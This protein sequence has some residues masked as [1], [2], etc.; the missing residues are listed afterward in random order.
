MA[1]TLE[2][3]NALVGALGVKVPGSILEER[4]KAEQFAAQRQ[5]ILAE[6]NDKPDEWSLKAIFSEVMAHAADAAGKKQ[7]DAALKHLAEAE[8]LL[9]E[10]DVAP[11][12]PPQPASAPEILTPPPAPQPLPTAAP[13]PEA[14]TT[15]KEGNF[16]LVEL[17]KSRLAYDSLRKS[18]QHQ[19]QQL[20]K[21]ILDGV[22]SH[23][24]DESTEDEFEEGEVAAGVKQL[25]SILQQLDERLIDK[26]DEA[27]NAASDAERQARHK[28]AGKI[29]LEYQAFAAG[30][31]MLATID[32]NGFTKTTIREAVASTLKD[33][34]G[35]W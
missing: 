20:E 34:A 5:K 2:E 35:K 25:Y 22:Q 6:G 31:P 1:L 13:Q 15:S 11:A 10:T 9:Q 18:V 21:S 27:L 16:S 19:L 14:V 30:D 23:N 28:E 3:I 17:Q 7:F 12:P 33:L 26:L 29:V 24:A 4:Q 32:E 8:Q